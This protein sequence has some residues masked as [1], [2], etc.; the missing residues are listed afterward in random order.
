MLRFLNI[1]T[2][3]MIGLAATAS[4]GLS[5]PFPGS[6][7][8]T[9]FA[10]E[11][12]L[13][14]ELDAPLKELF[15]KNE[16][17]KTDEKVYVQGKLSYFSDQNAKITLPVRLRVKGHSTVAFCPFKK[18][19]IKFKGVDASAT[20]FKNMKSIDLNTHC[21]EIN[22]LDEY[23]QHFNGSYYN[24]REVVA[25]KMA[26]VL[27]VPTFQVRAL[28]IRYK[29]TGLKVDQAQLP[30]QAFFVE[31]TGDF[32]KRIHAREIKLEKLAAAPPL[33]MRTLP[34]ISHDDL[35]RAILFNSLIQ[36]SDWD[37]PRGFDGRDL[38]NMKLIE[39]QPGKWIPL[40]YDFSLAPVVTL[41]R[42]SLPD[43][44]YYLSVDQNTRMT[45]LVG[46]KEK[47]AELY[48]LLETLKNDEPA[49]KALKKCL[50]DFFEYN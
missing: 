48:A 29:N 32:L 28:S 41:D 45:I 39:I 22:E 18:M 27:Q 12:I 49:Y 30:Y 8:G 42:S 11:D 17:N 36:N 4:Y 21:A 10:D 24:H 5:E 9:V 47:R 38:W 7:N 50:D 3:V 44:S 20:I 37:F 34:K 35:Y 43:V 19:E 46:F 31:D 40:I 26:K 14:V 1:F 13:N 33:D 6:P 15:D 23:E 16:T 25:Y 2:I